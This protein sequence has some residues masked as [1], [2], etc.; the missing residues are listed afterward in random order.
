RIWI[1]VFQLFAIGDQL[2][3]LRVHID[4]LYVVIRDHDI[5]ARLP[6]GVLDR[7]LNAIR[8]CIDGFDRLTI[9]QGTSATWTTLRPDMGA[10]LEF[11]HRREGLLCLHSFG[12]EILGRF[13]LRHSTCSAEHQRYDK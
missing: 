8:S 3:L 1:V 11:V 4:G 9:P 12:F 7:N 13:I 2:E 5:D 6:S 10:W